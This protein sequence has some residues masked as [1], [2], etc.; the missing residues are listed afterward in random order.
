MTEPILHLTPND[1]WLA[2]VGPAG[3]WRGKKGALP[4]GQFVSLR[5]SSTARKPPR[6]L[7]WQTH[8]I[9]ASTVWCYW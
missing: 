8:S 5:A 3:L 4:R 6:L 7:V 1:A 2:A 9:A